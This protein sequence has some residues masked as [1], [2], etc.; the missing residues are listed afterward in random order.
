[1]QTDTQVPPA[2]SPAVIEALSIGSL[3]DVQWQHEDDLCDC[4]YQRI[5]MW[6]NP[7]LAETLEIRLCCVWA[8]LAKQY[9]DFVRT[10]P[11]YF[12][13][14]TKQ[15]ETQ[16]WEW[17]GEAEM[18]RAIWYRH[19]ARKLDRPLAEIRAEYAERDELRPKGYVKP[20]PVPLFIHIMGDWHPINLASRRGA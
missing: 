20:E 1:M 5:G 10:I 14:N 9:P 3:P 13:E 12:N 15:W 2:L 18:P 4:T 16:P 8:E 7:Y 19:L 6:K 17:N 11:G